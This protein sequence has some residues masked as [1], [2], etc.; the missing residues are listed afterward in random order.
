MHSFIAS[1]NYFCIHFMF[2]AEFWSERLLKIEFYLFFYF[3]RWDKFEDS[4][5]T[6]VFANGDHCWNGP[7][8]SLKVEYIKMPYLIVHNIVY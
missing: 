7:D 4:Y 3:R 2:L 6:M 8:R 5:R 1:L